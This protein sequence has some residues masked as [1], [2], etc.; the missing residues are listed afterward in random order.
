MKFLRNI[1]D[2]QKPNFQKDGKFE[3]FHYLF[4]AAETFL[5]VPNLVTKINV[6]SVSSLG[7]T[8]IAVVSSSSVSGITLI[9]GLPLD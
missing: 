1:L 2:K 3:K 5:Y 4:E 9:S 6:L 8:N 7:N